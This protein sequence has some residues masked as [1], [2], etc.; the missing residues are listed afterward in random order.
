M[1]LGASAGKTELVEVT[2]VAGGVSGGAARHAK[3]GLFFAKFRRSADP[4]RF[5]PFSW[6]QRNRK[7]C[8]RLLLPCGLS[9]GE[10]KYK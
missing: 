1:R 4:M 3:A 2:P 7:P 8:A 10:L 6:R 9:Q 5:V